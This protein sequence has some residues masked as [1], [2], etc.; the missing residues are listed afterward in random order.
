VGK[1][2]HHVALIRGGPRLI[3]KYMEG[4][5]LPTDVLEYVGVFI[6]HDDVEGAFAAA[7][8]PTHDDWRPETLADPLWKSQVRVAL[9][10]IKEETSRFS[11]SLAS[12]NAGTGG[13]QPLGGFSEELGNL[14]TQVGGT[15]RAGVPP[16]GPVAGGGGS[17]GTRKLRA[18][19][20]QIDEIEYEIFR[21][22]RVAAI[23]FQVF[24]LPGTR[25][26][27]VRALTR[28]AVGDGDQTENEPPEGADL[29]E[30]LAWRTPN[31]E[32]LAGGVDLARIPAYE[33]GVWK[34]LVSMPDDAVI[35]VDL[36]PE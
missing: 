9:Q 12:V 33:H 21:G 2:S 35:T 4:P 28:V 22:R 5:P 11:G 15:G 20:R 14:L 8:P 23:A 18:S 31:G 25:S 27:S 24:P 10:K 26:T 36:Q 30:I 7:E 13:V 32:Y 29:P 16:V 6:S 1:P 3:V 19:V 34:V 17:G